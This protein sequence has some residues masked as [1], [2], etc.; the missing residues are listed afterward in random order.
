[1][2]QAPRRSEESLVGI[3]LRGT[4]LGL[5]GGPYIKITGCPIHAVS[6]HEWAF[7]HP[8]E[9]WRLAHPYLAIRK[10]VQM[11]G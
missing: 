9:L 3:S 8:R 6:S 2:A 10:P 7:A 4:I 11:I 5:A 1:M